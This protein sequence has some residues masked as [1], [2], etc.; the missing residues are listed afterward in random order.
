MDNDLIDMPI[1]EVRNENFNREEFEQ[2]E[3]TSEYME[4]HYYNSKL[5]GGADAREH[6]EYNMFW[7]DY[8]LFLT[9]DSK[10]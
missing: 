7:S 4:T 5:I 1:Q 10:T 3:S 2:M 9:D 8:A 6:I